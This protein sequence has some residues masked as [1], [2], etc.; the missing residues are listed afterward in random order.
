MLRYEYWQR[1]NPIMFMEV[2]LYWS[3]NFGRES[4]LICMERF[5]TL[6]LYVLD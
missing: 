5:L 6:L 1:L 2:I 3:K 4:V